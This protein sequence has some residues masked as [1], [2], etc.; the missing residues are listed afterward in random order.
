MTATYVS[1]MIKGCDC[2]FFMS[3]MSIKTHFRIL[4]HKFRTFLFDDPG[5]NLF[6]LKK[7]LKYHVKILDMTKSLNDI[8]ALIFFV[9]VSLTALQI[10]FI[11][12]QVLG[13]SEIQQVI[14]KF[15]IFSLMF[16]FLVELFVLCYGGDCIT[17][18]NFNISFAI[19]ES[20]WYKLPARE[21]F[22]I[23]IVIMRTQKLLHISAGIY[24]ASLSTYMTVR[25]Y[26]F[27]N[28]IF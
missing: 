19:Q 16:S 6:E 8:F 20:A 14:D 15:P 3:A 10:C 5:Q 13:V 9:Q 4:Q 25:F 18:E 7:L 28:Y 12:I 11:V 26:I 21:R 2:I 1:I 23:Q 27:V 17:H 24:V 22:I